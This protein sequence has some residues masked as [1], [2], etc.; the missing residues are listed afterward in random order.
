MV[1][2][3]EAPN[4]S[5]WEDILSRMA[6]DNAAKQLSCSWGGGPPDATA[7]QIFKQMAAQ[8][9]TFF[10]ATGDSDAFT[11]QI[12]FP[13]DSPNIVEVGGTTLNTI[14]P[15]GAWSSETTWNWGYNQGGYVGSSGGISSYYPIP[16]WQ[17]G[18][19]MSA[20]QG[21]TTFRNLPDVALTADNVYAVSDNGQAGD[22]GGTSCAAP[23]WA[24]FTALVNQQ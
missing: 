24:A 23:L 5:P 7:E 11:G 1:I 19:S 20:S 14:S 18:V 8:G 12:P 10:N 2:V 15:G 13:S 9:Q 22:F 16:S 21:S 6:N 3:Y 17:Q 4:S